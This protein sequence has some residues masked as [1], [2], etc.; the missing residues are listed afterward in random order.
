[1]AVSYLEWWK[2]WD[3]EAQQSMKIIFRIIIKNM[4]YIFIPYILSK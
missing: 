4:F 1:M 2:Y 3:Y